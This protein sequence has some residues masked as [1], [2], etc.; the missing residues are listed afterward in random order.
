MLTQK[1]YF[2][3]CRSACNP[4]MGCSLCKSEGGVPSTASGHAQT[5]SGG[6]KT[7][8][9]TPS[10][11][12]GHPKTASGRASTASG[13]APTASGR[14]QTA[15]GT[16]KTASVRRNETFCIIPNPFWQKPSPTPIHPGHQGKTPNP[17]GNTPKLFFIRLRSEESRDISTVIRPNENRWQANTTKGRARRWERE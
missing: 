2:Y 11:A 5:A 1:A 13:P 10:T 14:P 7:A 16:E 8:S 15:S 3:P 17:P 4:L 6:T 12:S 9:G